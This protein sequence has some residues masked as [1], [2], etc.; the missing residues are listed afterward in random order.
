[1]KPAAFPS[2][3]FDA[4]RIGKVIEV[5]LA[6]ALAR[7]VIGEIE[8]GWIDWATFRAGATRVWSPPSVGEQ[9]LVISPDG[10]LEGAFAFGALFSEDHPAPG[11]S[12]REIIWFQDGAVLAYDPEAHHL[13]VQ[14]P[15][16]ATMT[17]TAD[18]GI[19]I[20]GDITLNGTLTASED[21]VASGISLKTHKHGG[22]QAGGAIT[23]TPQ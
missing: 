21:V 23:G 17:M 5:D 2:S 7:V 8:S 3:Q 10:D 15:A 1:V 13:D 4:L 19:T 18:G 9:C 12:L 16:G 20:N 6:K 11:N 14:L 22:V